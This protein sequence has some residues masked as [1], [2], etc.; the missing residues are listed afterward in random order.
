[1]LSER[2]PEGLCSLDPAIF[3]LKGDHTL[4]QSDNAAKKALDEWWPLIV[5]HNSNHA[6]MIPRAQKEMKAGTP[7][8]A[9]MMELRT[10]A[11]NLYGKE[12]VKDA[13][14]GDRVE[15]LQMPVRYFISKGYSSCATEKFLVSGLRLALQGTRIVAIADMGELVGFMKAHAP[16]GKLESQSDAWA[17]FHTADLA[18]A[19]LLAANVKVFYGTVGAGEV[20]FVP[21]G[22]VV[23]ECVGIRIANHYCNA[24]N[25]T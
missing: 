7:E 9:S 18:T 19:T 14:V 1:L 24:W 21:P 2:M 8:F 17:F 13:T 25:Q 10:L 22:A 5:K 23:S 15:D 11:E 16:D 6:R 20:L 12:L 4:L 3:R